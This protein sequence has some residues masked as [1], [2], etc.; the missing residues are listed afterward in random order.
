MRRLNICEERGT[1]IDKVVAAVE[2]FALPAPVFEKPPG[3]TRAL[4]FAHKPFREMDR[5]ERLHACYMH[6]CLRHV[7]QQPMTN[8]SLRARFEIADKNASIA[9][10]L[11]A[12]AVDEGLIVVADPAAG[13]RL[14]RYLPF[15]A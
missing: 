3:F 12:D 5:Q 14:R 4:L 13:L 10:R 9:S 1:G 6:A 11:L 15:W 2:S 7:T 8:S